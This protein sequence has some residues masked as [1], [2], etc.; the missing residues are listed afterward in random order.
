MTKYNKGMFIWSGL[1]VAFNLGQWMVIG[2]TPA[3]YGLG[4]AWIV[5]FCMFIYNL[6]KHI[7]YVKEQK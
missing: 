2:F 5:S 3:W 6:I 7:E 1:M 4:V